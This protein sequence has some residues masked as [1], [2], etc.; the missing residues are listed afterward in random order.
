MFFSLINLIADRFGRLHGEFHK[1]IALIDA[2]SLQ[3][4]TPSAIRMSQSQFEIELAVLWEQWT[5][6]IVYSNIQRCRKARYGAFE[7]R[8][9]IYLQF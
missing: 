3:C 7:R 2:N 9:A 8:E 4:G 6:K 1:F 5:A